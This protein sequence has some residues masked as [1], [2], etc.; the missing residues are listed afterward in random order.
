VDLL[1][2]SGSGGTDCD[3]VASTPALYAAAQHPANRL[4]KWDRLALPIEHGELIATSANAR[5]CDQHGSGELSGAD[6]AWAAIR[7]LITGMKLIDAGVLRPTRMG[8]TAAELLNALRSKAR[9]RNARAGTSSP[10][11]HTT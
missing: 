2:R 4:L 8:I 11:H 7:R 10:G 9:A 5:H 1:E 3:A 6:P